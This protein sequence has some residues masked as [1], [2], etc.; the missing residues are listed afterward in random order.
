MAERD[1]CAE[2]QS[3]AFR[4]HKRVFCLDDKLGS[5]WQFLS[6]PPGGHDGKNTAGRWHHRQCLQGNSFP[7]VSNFLS[8]VPDMLHTGSNFGCSAF[9][10]LLYR[11]VELGKLDARAENVV[12]KT[13]GGSD[14]VAWIM[15]GVHFM[16]VREGVFYQLDWI[17]L[18]PGHSHTLLDQALSTGWLDGCVSSYF[19]HY[20]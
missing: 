2:L 5:H 9:V 4:S 15:H 3:N 17:K 20:G 19:A 18:R 7:G 1:V 16:L 14:N 13:D 8:V 10:F 11:L 12:R 6:V